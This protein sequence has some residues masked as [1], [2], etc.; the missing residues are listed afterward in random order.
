MPSLQS[1]TTPDRR[2]RSPH[3]ELELHDINQLFNSIDPSPLEKRDLDRN[4]EEFITGWMEEYPS[5]ATVSLRIH[6]EE[7]PADDPTNLLRAAIHNYFA[8]RADVNHTRFKRLMQRGRTSLAI[9]LLFL[10]T[11]LIVSR[12]LF[13]EGDS[14]WAGIGRESL[15]IAGWVAM[16]RPME[17]YLY[18]WWPLRRRA[19]IFA[20]L[21]LIPVE[22]VRRMSK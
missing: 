18:D 8:Y 3:I 9:G 12:L 4:A 15:T 10:V 17:I 6:L 1:S 14:A 16:W 20:K 21:G 7:W 22:V 11:C 5:T 19:R 2:K 13:G